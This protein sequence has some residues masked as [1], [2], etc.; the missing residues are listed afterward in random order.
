MKSSVGVVNFEVCSLRAICLDMD[1][2]ER[3]GMSVCAKDRG[4]VHIV[5]EAVH[6]VATLEDTVIEKTAP[7]LLSILVQEVDPGRVARPANT[8][9]WLSSCAD[10]LTDKDI[11]EVTCW[12][13]LILCLNAFRVHEVVFRCFDVRIDNNY[14][15][16][17]SCFNLR[18]H[19]ANLS[20]RKVFG[21]EFEVLVASWVIVLLS[22]LDI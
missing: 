10:T 12:L 14:N 9:E 6:V 21:I 4:L 15:S 16:S 8:I 13:L 19:V 17:A 2:I 22:P 20:V 18:V 5:P 11:R 3:H 7:E 1:S